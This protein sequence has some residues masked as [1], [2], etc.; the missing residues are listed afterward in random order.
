MVS[1]CW[2]CWGIAAAL[3]ND[4]DKDSIP[5][6]TITTQISSAGD[7]SG[8]VTNVPAGTEVQIT[9][10]GQDKDGNALEQTIT[11]TVDADGNYTAEVPADFADGDITVNA[12]TT[13]RNGNMISA[14]DKLTSA[15]TDDPVT[16]G[17]DR[18]EG[19]IEVD[20]DNKGNI[21]G[22]TTDVVAGST[23]VITVE[24]FDKDG[25]PIQ[26]EVVAIVQ[27]D[28]SYTA[29]VPADFADGSSID[30]EATTTDRNGNTISDTD[31]LA[32]RVED[33]PT[34]PEDESVPG[35]LDRI[36]G[37]ITVDVENN[38]NITGGTTDVVPGSEVTLTIT[39][40]DKDGNPLERE[41]TTT[42]DAD[43]NYTTEVPADF[44][45]GDITVKAETVDRNGNPVDAED[46]LVKTD[47]DNDPNTPDQGGLDRVEGAITVEIVET[48]AITGTTTD[49]APGTDVVLTITGKD[50]DGNNVTIS[51]TVTTDASGNYSSAVT[52]AEGIVDGSA[53]T[54]VA[55][56]TDRNGQGV[57]PA[58]DSIAAQG[59]NDTDPTTPEDTGLD[60]VTGAITV[61]I[62]ETGAI[63]GTT[64]DVAPGTD[65][66]LTITGKDADGNNVTI[67][68]TVTTDASGN[69][70]SAVTVAEGIVDG[71]AVTVVANTTDRN[72]QGVGPAT[73]S[74]AAQG[75]N[76][77]DPTTPEDTGLD[78]VTGAITVDIVETG[79]ITGTTTDVA[80]GTDVVLTI[81]GKDADGNNVTISKTVTTDASGNYSSAVTV[82]E[83][84]VDGSAVTVVANTTDRNGQGVGP[85]T[86]SIA[87]QGDNDT[88]PTTPEDTGLDL[89]T[90]AITVDIVETGAITG[91][92]TDVAPGTDVVL[93]ITGKDADGNNVTISKTVTTDASGNYSSAVT[94]AE[95]IV[96]G[97]AVTV[98][99]NTTDRN[100]QGVGPATDSIAAQGD[101]DTDPTT[102]EDTGLDLVTG[103]IT[104]DIVETGAITGTTT[105]VAPGT[106][107]VLTITGKDADGNNVTISKTVTTDA[108]GNYSSAVTVAEGI[109]DGSAVTVVA[110]TTDRNGQGVGPATDSIAAQG[111]NDTDPT[112]PEDTGLD[113]VTGAITVDIVETGA[114][115]GTTT[116]V[117]P[118]TDVVLTITGK[119]ADG[120]N[121]T[122]SKTVTTDA[123]GNYSSAVTV[124]EGIVDGSA[125]T[126]VANTTDRNGQGVGPAT[127]SIAA[128][129]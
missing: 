84:I 102:P 119:D 65:V 83:G 66:V 51:K 4:D 53:V 1:G 58:T 74:I 8:T 122:I 117:A 70:S 24:G 21:T 80:P 109:V 124:A 44:A 82:A 47:H 90:G 77:T 62:V 116:D 94:V 3:N 129:R 46:S 85:A 45:D 39:G 96:D 61:D 57:G 36:D 79:A 56:T 95:G 67:S 41:V 75:D 22:T 101:N 127:D 81:T 103:A 106:D 19:S 11:T 107:V 97:S 121:V 87:A 72:G 25:N 52:V 55:N 68:K 38:G 64:T 120:N 104:V 118:G 123:S 91:T 114:I 43:G 18:E 27:P 33:D 29:E 76:D 69:Y 100:G 128:Q 49:V 92:T 59:D 50:A 89:V 14:E 13:D 113:L 71:S 23:V 6:G 17:L 42:V 34:T 30:V 110:N 63:T 99:A 60:L 20:V 28:G 15:K 86:D 2:G 48:G 88:D 126:V 10:K 12:E 105:D 26:E 9:I 54:V 125:V 37:A 108:S 35:G 7:I 111:D 73:D 5:N 78:L 40:Q 32:G 112:T 31:S 93:T 98:V 16:G 115:T